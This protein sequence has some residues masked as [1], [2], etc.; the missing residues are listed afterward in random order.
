MLS[1][2]IVL[3]FLTYFPA[4]AF[5][6]WCLEV[7]YASVNTGKFVNRGFLNGA[8][9]PIYGF[10]AVLFILFLNPISDNLPTFLGISHHRKYARACRWLCLRKIVPHEVVGLLSRTF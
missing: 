8:V 1:E 5:L 7:I 9:C 4:Y 3:T 10:G 6:G 2:H